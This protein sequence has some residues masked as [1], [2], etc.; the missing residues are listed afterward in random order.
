MLERKDYIAIDTVL[1]FT[2]EF[3]DRVARSTDDETLP[4]AYTTYSEVEKQLLYCGAPL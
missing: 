2:L 1:S 3:I 4:M